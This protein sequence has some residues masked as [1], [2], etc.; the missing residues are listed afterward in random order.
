MADLKGFVLSF[1]FCLLLQCAPSLQAEAMVFVAD[2]SGHAISMADF[3]SDSL[4]SITFDAL[5]FS[6]VRYPMG[7]DYD[8][9]T[10]MVYWTEYS[11]SGSIR[12]AN[13]NGSMQ[14][15]IVDSTNA[16][17]SMDLALDTSRGKVFWT[18]NN[19]NRIMSANLNG[20]S[21]QIIINTDLF[22]PCGIIVHKEKGVMFWTDYYYDRIER[23]N[24][25][26]GDRNVIVS[27]GLSYPSG[28]E[29][30][31]NGKD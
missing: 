13:I 10:R 21:Q 2:Y 5:P 26:G 15:V 30:N 23:A 20:S 22:Y 9:D 27:S 28:L 4:D 12:R 7:I 14:S 11:G 19:Q 8:P 31:A 3:S 6:S 25:D 24:L 18:D 17:Y 1:L 29:F 16:R